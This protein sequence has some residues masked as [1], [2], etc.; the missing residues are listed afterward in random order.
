[1][2]KVHG[3]EVIDN[4]LPQKRGEVVIETRGIVKNYGHLQAL[5]G[6]DLVV[7]AGEVLALIGDNG[8]G[9]STLANIICGAIPKTSGEL[10]CRGKV[11]ELQSIIGAQE[12]GI[13]VVYQ[14]LA[15]A[16]DLTVA[17]NMF[18]GN[19]ILRKRL[20]GK[21]GFVN[22]KAMLKKSADSLAKLGI[23][24]KSMSVPVK[25]LSGG[26]RQALAVAKA[27]S[28]ASS[29]LILDEPTAALGARQ[30]ALVYR[31]IRAAA[32]NNLAVIIISHDIPRMVEQADRIS[33][34]RHGIV[35][36]TVDAKKTDT[37]TVLSKMLT[38][39]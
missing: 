7:H 31:T 14:D 5:R 19:E 32:D 11:V 22:K 30:S 38:G 13:Q 25:S 23:G 21:L 10:I 16:P 26:E 3:E 34:M 1:M 37:K 35:I 15:L 2:E 27:V 36:D 9:K 24:L 28:W 20:L 12:L 17:E 6:A 29:A 8:A 18:L 4:L 33:I 39:M